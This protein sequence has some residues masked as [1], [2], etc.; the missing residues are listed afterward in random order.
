M[1]WE[2]RKEV[3][4]CVVLVA[5]G[6][7]GLQYVGQQPESTL[8]TFLTCCLIS[9]SKVCAFLSLGSTRFSNSFCREDEGKI[10]GQGWG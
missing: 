3:V 4:G 7:V 2:R 9:S 6:G 5:K 1:G 8:P 10:N